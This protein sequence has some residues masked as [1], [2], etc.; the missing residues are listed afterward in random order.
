MGIPERKDRE[1]EQRREEIL[2][3]AEKVFFDRGL[4]QATMDEIA[5]H[6]ELSKGTLY[7]YYQ[8]KEDLYLGVMC[9]GMKIMHDMF[10]K[11]TSTG[12]PTVKLIQNVG[13]AYYE[14]F[15]VYKKYCQMFAFFKNSQ[16]HSQVS[17][18][19]IVECTNLDQKSWKLVTDVIQ[20][21]I[22]DGTFRKE[23]DP[24]EMGVILWSN[25]NGIMQLM[26]RP[27]ESQEIPGNIDLEKLLR[28]SN[29]MIVSSMLTEETKQRYD[30]KP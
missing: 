1:K 17:D 7:L 15:K 25:S 16:L 11:A 19:M 28:K 2:N 14:F 10:Q 24:L 23:L 21:G 26:D 6:A 9:R 5:Q 30:L 20:K 13:E 22:E 27:V 12:E 3:A 18:A 8:S 4:A 29:S